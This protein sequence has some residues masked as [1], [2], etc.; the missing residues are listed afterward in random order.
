V[1]RRTGR[2]AGDP[3]TR[4]A[5]LTAARQRF[6]AQGYTAATIRAI[7]TDANVD[8]ALILHYFGNKVDLFA[9]AMALPAS[10]GVMVA[11]LADVP[12]DQLGEAILTGVVELW[13]QPDFLDAWLGL[14]R[15]AMTDDKAMTMLQEFLGNAVLGPVGERLGG[16]DA[17]RR[18]ALVASPIVGLGMTRYILR[19]EPLASAPRTE[20]LTTVG[21]TLQ[22]YLT[23]RL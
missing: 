5:I 17:A 2:R 12:D 1:S 10:P 7:A 19:V 21:P 8:P 20:I 15:S 13:E 6:A 11:A 9:A 22:R 14:L 18:V 23:G 3:G 16:A 4:E